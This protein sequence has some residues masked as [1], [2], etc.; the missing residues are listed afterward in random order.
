M[1]PSALYTLSISSRRDRRLDADKVMEF[2]TPLL[3]A[4][5]SVV[6]AIKL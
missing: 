4:L 2:R 3:L 5:D 1:L 6:S